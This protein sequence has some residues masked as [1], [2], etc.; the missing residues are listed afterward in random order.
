MHLGLAPTSIEGV[1]ALCFSPSGAKVLLVWCR[2]AWSMP[3]GATI[4]GECKIQTLAREVREEVGVQVDFSQDVLYIG[5]WSTGRARDNLTNDNFSAFAVRM[6]SEVFHNDCKEVFEASWFEWRPLL[7]AWVAQGKPDDRRVKSLD[8]QQPKGD[9]T[10]EK[11]DNG[12]RNILSGLVLKGLD[13][14]ASGCGLR[15][16]W[17]EGEQDGIWNMKTSWGALA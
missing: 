15:V 13:I 2:G 16:R 12:D 10:I 17:E 6:K 1:A 11:Y 7:D 14:Y 4:A 9:P 8:L 3:G 5:G